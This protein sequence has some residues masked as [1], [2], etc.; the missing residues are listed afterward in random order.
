[1]ICF[2]SILPVVPRA[3]DINETTR[4]NRLEG[5]GRSTRA[6]RKRSTLLLFVSLV[7]ASSATSWAKP[8]KGVKARLGEL[9]ARVAELGDKPG[10]PGA[11]GPPGPTVFAV[12]EKPGGM[13]EQTLL[14]SS[15]GAS[16]SHEGNGIFRLTFSRD[17]SQCAAIAVGSFTKATTF[18]ATSG[19]QTIDVTLLGGG[20]AALQD[21]DFTLIAACP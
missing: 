4:P 20:G 1:M 16:L 19:P 17:V 18:V 6:T 7:A 12:V 14:R 2:F 21:D 10:T 5:P 13:G 3:I 15:P 11:Q 9:E 8:Q